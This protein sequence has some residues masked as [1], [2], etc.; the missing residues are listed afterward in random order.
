MRKTRSITE[1][2]KSFLDD[3]I[4]PDGIVCDFT[5]GTGHDTLWFSGLVPA[6]H[7]YAFDVQPLALE[8]TR[9]RLDAAGG[10]PNVTL[11]LDS[12]EHFD[13]YVGVPFDAGMFNLGYLPTSD[14]VLT[15]KA[16]TSLAAVKK[17]VEHVKVGGTV[18]VVVYPGHPEGRREGEL[19]T[20][21]AASLDPKRFD[22][23]CYRLVNVPDCPFVL[24]FQKRR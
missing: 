20:A 10:C 16:E 9:E 21:F 24:A 11:I 2:A 1:V 12:H 3:C 17:A 18:V 13:R 14:R 8:R 5:M 4:P 7:V 19:L 15:T 23:T 6:G 22:A